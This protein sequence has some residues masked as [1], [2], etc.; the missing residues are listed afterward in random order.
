MHLADDTG[1]WST[2][3]CIGKPGCKFTL[4][5]CGHFCTVMYIFIFVITQVTDS[6]TPISMTMIRDHSN[7]S[8]LPLKTLAVNPNH[9]NRYR[10]DILWSGYCPV[11][12]HVRPYFMYTPTGACVHCYVCISYIVK[13]NIN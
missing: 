2:V 4:E 5:V 7:P 10:T 1:I 6:H 3:Y 12:M 8:C 11:T 9:P 13:I